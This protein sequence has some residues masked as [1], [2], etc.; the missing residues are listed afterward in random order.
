MPTN[1]PKPPI[2]PL[3]A[4]AALGIDGLSTVLEFGATATV[5]GAALVPAIIVVSGVVC[6]V[7]VVL[8]ERFVSHRPWGQALIIAVVIGFLTALPYLCLGGIAGG[9]AV[10]WAGLYELQESSRLPTSENR[11]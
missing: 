4:L 9:V 8:I 6:L 3:S 11:P 2:N 10:G 1:I 5:V 7:G